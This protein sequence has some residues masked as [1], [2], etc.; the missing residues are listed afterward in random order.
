MMG[1]VMAGLASTQATERVTRLI[2]A[3]S[4]IRPSS[5][6]VPNSRSCQYRSWYAPPAVPRVKR[7]PSAGG[8]DRECL[9]DSKPPAIGL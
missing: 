6:T 5:S 3:F 1:A 2:P 7:V 4:A 9:P 8:A